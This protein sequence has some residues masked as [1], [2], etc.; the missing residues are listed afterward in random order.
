MRIRKAMPTLGVLGVYT[1]RVLKEHGFGEIH[2]VFDHFYPGIMTLG[3]AAMAEDA[4]A[5]VARQ[6]PGCVPWKDDDD[7]QEYAR[8]GLEAF[9]PTIEL[10][11]PL[12]DPGDARVIENFKR[13]RGR[14]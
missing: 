12:A 11:G 6:V 1:G 2:E 7:W 3:C 13:L 9:G 14:P 4:A 10:D 5:E 8:R